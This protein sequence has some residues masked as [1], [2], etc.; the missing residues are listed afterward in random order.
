M[1]GVNE[2]NEKTPSLFEQPENV[3]EVRA[4]SMSMTIGVEKLTDKFGVQEEEYEYPEIP[5]GASSEYDTWLG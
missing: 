3:K 4:G 2:N 1:N 5:E